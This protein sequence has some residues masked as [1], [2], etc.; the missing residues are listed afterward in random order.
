MTKDGAVFTR[1]KAKGE[2]RYPPCD[3]RDN[4]LAR[5][6]RRF[7]MY[8]M[9]DI[10]QYPRHIPYNSDKK[11]FQEKTGRESFECM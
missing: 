4:E 2:I 8:P 11:T 6:H 10:E 5:E 3:I 7:E 9:G 1:S